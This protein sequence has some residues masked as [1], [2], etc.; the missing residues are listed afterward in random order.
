MFAEGERVVVTNGVFAGL[1][2]VA[3]TPA[4]AD[5]PTHHVRIKLW[6]EEVTVELPAG[7]LRRT[8]L[9][10]PGPVPR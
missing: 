8:D 2:G 9:S 3:V 7:W 10:P 6:D 1:A 4:D 5:E